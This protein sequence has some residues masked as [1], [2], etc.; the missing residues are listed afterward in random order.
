MANPYPPSLRRHARNFLWITLVVLIYAAALSWD[1]W[2]SHKANVQQQLTTVAELGARSIDGY[3]G[4]LQRDLDRLAADIVQGDPAV[5]DAWRTYEMFKRFAVVHPELINVSLL[6]PDGS[7]PFTAKRPPGVQ[8]LSLTQDESIK[9]YLDGLRRGE[10]PF[11]GQPTIGLTRKLVFIPFRR[12]LRDGQGKITG[13]ISA[14][15]PPE[16]LQS[17]WHDAPIVDK[18]AIGI[19]KDDGYLVARYPMPESGGMNEVYGRPRP[20]LAFNYLK[21]EH[22]PERAYV[23][24]EKS[25]IDGIAKLFVFRRLPSYPVTFLIGFPLKEI[26]ALWWKSVRDAYF[27][28]A[29]LVVL[30]T[31]GYVYAARRERVWS[32]VHASDEAERLQ[33]ERTLRVSEEKLRGLY[34]L[35]P[36]GIAL[37]D[38]EGRFVQFNGAFLRI[39][40]YPGEELRA[41]DYWALAPHKY[42]PEQERQLEFLRAS[43]HYGPCEIEYVRKDGVVVPLRLNSVL[44][45]GNDGTQF[46]WSLV[47][48]I[49]AGKAAELAILR[50]RARLEKILRTASDGIHILDG[51]GLLIEA[52]DA[53][54]KMLGYDRSAIGR[55]RVEDWDT[56][57][58]GEAIRRRTRRMLQ[59]N[60]AALV[61]TQHRRSDGTIIDV[62][63]SVCPIE[64]EGR[65]LIYAASRDNTER[66]RVEDTRR[67]LEAQ[68]R[69]AQKMEALGTLAGG[70]AHDFNNIL[71]AIMGNAEL[72]RQD[73][74]ADHPAAASLAEIVKASARARDLVRQ[75]LTFG[76]QQT[77]DQHI[78]R[79]QDVVEESVKLLRATLPAGLELAMRAQ[80]DVPN[81]RGDRTQMHQVLM[82]LCSNSWQAM[83]GPV[84]RID[85]VLARVT[86]AAGELGA[87]IAPGVYAR[88]SVID[89]GRGMD[90]ATLERIFDPFFT[91]KAVGEGTGLGLAVV[92]GIV[93]RHGG[94]IAVHSAPGQ[95]STFD[96]YFPA[97]EAAAETPATGDRPRR[98]GGERILYLDDEEAL[99]LL[100]SRSL[101]RLGYQVQGCTRAEEA[102]ALFHADPSSIDLFVSDM[103]MPGAS[104]LDVAAEILRARPDLPVALTSGYVTDALR[105]Q[106]QALGVRAVIYKANTVDELALT[107]GRLLEETRGPVVTTH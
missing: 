18:A 20:G 81:V 90:E 46:I 31:A 98:G 86:A 17:Y 10:E 36:L 70:I 9:R 27:I 29:L 62:E 89:T 71:G 75:I 83:E 74:A 68:L 103:N 1:S 25:T 61:E 47:E 2:V 39:C 97:V 58:S 100:A 12:V 8:V 54:L 102:L 26:R 50:E 69:Q 99:V 80:P 37:T 22:F 42:R 41:L 78:V 106:A 49:S 35:S 38:L 13:I 16:H 56:Q 79:L 14:N 28:S 85:I 48:D 52:N 45:T 84:G 66:K 104:G 40:G 88:M 21:N 33:I 94:A 82:N 76:R 64:I 19:I 92:D 59:T 34:E 53:F 43:G 91:T 51:T 95:G 96:L 93:K 63:I 44:I 5:T 105:A 6:R 15:I 24:E 32:L 77:Q 73:L 87:G 107:I 72:V 67:K 3:F 55:L 57:V 65:R 60:E 11:I 7:I 101:A 4:Q 30:A 23:E